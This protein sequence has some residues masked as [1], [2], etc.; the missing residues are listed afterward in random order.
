M[1]RLEKIA[2]STLVRDMRNQA[3]LE[4]D[5]N[6][7][8]KYKADRKRMQLNAGLLN[9]VEKLES[10]LSET[11]AGLNRIEQMLIQLLGK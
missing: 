11:N 4:S 9:R 8:N 10:S 6:K 7:V 2:D 1:N 5:M 3:L